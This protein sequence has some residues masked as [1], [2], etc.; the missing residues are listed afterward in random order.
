[1]RF[2]DIR[3]HLRAYSIAERR[4]TT[5]NHAFA[6]ALAPCEIFDEKV[7][8][9]ALEVLGQ[10]PDTDLVCVYCSAPAE[11]WDHLVGLVKKSILHGYGHQIGNLVPCC[12]P[13]NSR[14]GNKA[15]RDFL[16][17]ELPDAPDRKAL[18]HR[19]TEYQDTFARP[20][21]TLSLQSSCP[22]DW[23]RYEALRQEILGLMQ[24]ADQVAN[25]LRERLA[26]VNSP[27]HR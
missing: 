4:R 19:L 22:E 17:Q 5:V 27:G 11:T 1:M 3:R 16:M 13:C 24:E 14:K 26:W 7:M 12:K 6:S 9:K 8:R 2:A 18:E 15:W 25:R 21:D 23:A 10:D 20:I